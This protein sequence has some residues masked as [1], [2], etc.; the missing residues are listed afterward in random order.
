MTLDIRNNETESRF[1]TTV[2]GELA[3]AEYEIDDNALVLTHTL[4]PEGISTRGVASGIIRHALEH[5]KAENMRV[6]P[7]CSFAAAYIKRHPE[8]EELLAS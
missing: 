8:F 6:V 7:Q 2:D 3:F 5:A 4:V 1:E